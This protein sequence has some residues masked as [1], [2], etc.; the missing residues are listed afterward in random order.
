MEEMLNDTSSLGDLRYRQRQY[1]IQF[2]WSGS[3]GIS[4]PASDSGLEVS[5]A[6]PG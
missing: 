6:Q 3:P 2:S 5:Y 4:L 1:G